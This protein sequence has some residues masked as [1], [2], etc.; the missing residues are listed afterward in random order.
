MEKLFVGNNRDRVLSERVNAVLICLS[1]LG[2]GDVISNNGK[3][4]VRNTPMEY[5]KRSEKGDLEF[6]WV[7]KVFAPDNLLGLQYV[8]RNNFSEDECSL[9]KIQSSS[10]IGYR[11]FKLGEIVSDGGK[12]IDFYTTLFH[13]YDLLKIDSGFVPVWSFTPNTMD[14]NNPSFDLTLR[15]EKE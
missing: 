8:L 1:K 6:V 14:L 7:S 4:E 5:C 15:Y 10:A 11:Y 12:F 13:F 2:C 3:Q 9:L